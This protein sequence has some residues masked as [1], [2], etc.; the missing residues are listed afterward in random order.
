[1]ALPLWGG[2]AYWRFR[3]RREN[4]SSAFRPLHR[5]RVRDMGWVQLNQQFVQT[6]M[7]ALVMI[8]SHEVLNG[9]PQ[10]SFPERTA[11]RRFFDALAF[12][13]VSY[14]RTDKLVET[15]EQGKR[16]C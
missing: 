14:S 6:R 3:W 7:V 4:I 11:L 1:V 10:R 8:M 16:H 15:P 12:A 13:N 9:C 2:V 5:A